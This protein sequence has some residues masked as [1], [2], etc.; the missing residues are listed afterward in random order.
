MTTFRV[1][2]GTADDAEAMVRTLHVAQAY[3]YAAIMPVQFAIDRIVEIGAVARR[4]R[5]QLA[6]DTEVEAAGGEPFRRWWLAE[7][8]DGEVLAVAAAGFGPC[9][10]EADY[11]PAPVAYNLE[12]LYALPR[13]H[14]HGIG[15]A[16]FD[17]A[18]PAGEAAY[19]WILADNPR[20]QRFYE[21]NGFAADGYVVDCG[22]LWFNRP[23]FRMV[24]D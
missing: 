7:A 21:R 17:A 8:T 11:E 13:A 23:M 3:T 5:E 1:R 4:R 20:A 2:R 18:M 12:K 24:R 15:Q 22:D 10:W 9:D 16:L 19:L 14:G 6:R